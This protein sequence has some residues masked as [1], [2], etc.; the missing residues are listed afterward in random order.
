MSE[1][2]SFAEDCAE[3]LAEKIRSG[4][5]SRRDA[6]LALGALGLAPMAGSGPAHAQAKIPEVVMANWG[7]DSQKAFGQTF[8]PNYEKKTGGKIV[9]DG[10]GPSNAKLRAMVES[11]HITWDFCDCGAAAIGELGPLGMLESLDFSIIDKAKSNP[12]F[13]FEH[14][15]CNY[16]FSFVTAYDTKKVSGVPTLQDFFDVQKIPGKRLM[17]K[18]VQPM[19][20]MALMADGV[21]PDQLYP[22]D[23]ERAFKKIASIKDHLLFWET[24]AQSI[25]MLRS[26]EVV[27]AWMW[28]TRANVV[29]QDTQ[30]KID[31]TF[32]GGVL[33][34]GAWVVPKGNPAGKQ[35]MH[36]IAST[37]DPEPQIALLK[38]LGNGPANPQADT[39]VPPELQAINPASAKN[40]AVQAK[41]SFDWWMK[42]YP[43][44]LKAYRDMVAS[45]G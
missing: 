34:S 26:G 44:T 28:H 6:M 18:D 36:A 21:P 1:I 22:L 7:G 31:F 10:S 4:K 27:M 24:G 12:N 32:N 33:V 3:L 40:S 8:V 20:D 14:G 25:D 9:M 11:K 15:I 37:Q 2:Q 13:I 45:W 17:R 23:R 35:A 39:L 41:M 38:L 29:K 5:I 42:N 19:I 43:A 30:G 16:L